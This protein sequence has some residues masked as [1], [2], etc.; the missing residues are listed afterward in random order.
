MAI[1]IFIAVSGQSILD[2]CLNCYGT[3][4]YLLKLII[5][6]GYEDI[7]MVPVSGQTFLYDDSLVVDT[8]VFKQT[9]L[10]GVFFAT[11]IS[12]NGN[13]QSEIEQNP[14]GN[15]NH[16]QSPSYPYVPVN[17]VNNMYQ[18]TESTFY[19]TAINGETLITLT[20]NEGHPLT[21][22]TILQV[23]LETKPLKSTEFTWNPNT[24]QISI[25]KGM[26][27]NQTLFVLYQSMITV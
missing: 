23:E 10:S 8:N 22:K 9:T 19:T 17:P 26:F 13:L 5:D 25:P 16:N 12:N 27:K 7:N 21:N 11:N 18:K 6:S 2:V 3:L 1:K 20:D 14:N 24:S 4:D 15:T